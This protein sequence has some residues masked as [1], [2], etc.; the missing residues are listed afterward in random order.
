MGYFGDLFIILH[1]EEIV[2]SVFKSERR[3]D[4]GELH[5]L[6]QQLHTRSSLATVVTLRN[7]RASV[8]DVTAQILRRYAKNDSHIA[9]FEVD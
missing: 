1:I 9:D 2:T 7:W 4:I 3:A 8:C 5:L 6:M